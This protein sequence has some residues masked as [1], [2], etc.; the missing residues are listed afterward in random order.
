[1]WIVEFCAP[2]C[3]L[4]FVILALAVVSAAMMSSQT[5]QQKRR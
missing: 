1:M 2:F 5:S 3:A 4:G